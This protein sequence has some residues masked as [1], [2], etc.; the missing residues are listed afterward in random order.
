MKTYF[1]ILSLSLVPLLQGCA[2]AIATGAVAGAAVGVS[3][4]YDRRSLSTTVDDQS[5]QLQASA[6]LRNDKML[7][8]SAH[9]NVTSYNGI[10]LLTGETPTREL[11]ARAAGIVKTIPGIGRIYNELALIAPSSLV[12]RSNDTWIATKIKAKM[13]AKDGIN[14]ARVKIITERGTVY[15]LGL[16]T[17]QEASLATTIARHTEGVQ[18]VVKAFEYLPQTAMEDE[19]PAG[20]I[21]K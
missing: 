8:K 2:A 14:P 16:V 3:T 4:V 20:E 12:S 21:A 5:I 15:L 17:L 18:R 10:V 11:K 1:I 19:P 6:A 7:H 13:A 9:I